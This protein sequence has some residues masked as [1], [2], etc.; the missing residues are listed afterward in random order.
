MKIKSCPFCNKE[1][2]H[3]VRI[4]DNCKHIQLSVY[5]SDCSIEMRK[6]MPSGIPFYRLEEADT[7]LVEKW[8]DQ[9]YE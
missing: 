5:C 8:N 7:E 2:D 9:S 6:D 3:Y 1:A 4:S